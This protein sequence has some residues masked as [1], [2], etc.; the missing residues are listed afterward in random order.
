MDTPILLTIFSE[1]AET[2]FPFGELVQLLSVTRCSR[3][4]ESHSLTE[5]LSVSIDFTDVSLLSEDTYGRPDPVDPGEHDDHDD[6]SDH[7]YHDDHGDPDDHDAYDDHDDHDDN[8]DHDDY[9][10][11]DDHETFD[12]HD[13]K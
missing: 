11:Y 1:L 7:D 3:T 5:S 10:D 8:D 12:Y 2:T 4:D 6:P 13:K 9:D